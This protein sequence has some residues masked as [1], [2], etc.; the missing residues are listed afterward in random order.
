MVIL[1]D[2]EGSEMIQGLCDVA[3]KSGGIGNLNAVQSTLS[4]LKK[5]QSGDGSAPNNVLDGDDK[6]KQ[7]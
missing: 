3:L 7:S 5:M 1:A 2:K 6:N 4:S